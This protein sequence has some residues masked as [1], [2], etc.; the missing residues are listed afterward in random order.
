MA[1]DAGQ[2][3]GQEKPWI[4]VAV[5]TRNR[6]RLLERAVASVLAQLQGQT[7][8]LIVDN[9]SVDDTA[10]VARGL[11]DTSPA[12]RLA[13]EP[14]LGLANA[15]N[16]ALGAAR[17]QWIVFLDDDAVAEPGWLAAYMTFVQA[18]PSPAV[19]AV[20]G[21]VSPEYEVPP[22]AWYSPTANRL[23]LGPE[24]VRV[25]A[26]YGPWGGNI[27]YRR[28]AVLAVGL[29]DPALGRKDQLMAAHEETELNLRLERAGYQIW[30]LPQARIRHR[31]AADRLRLGWCV[32]AAFQSG[33]SKALVRWRGR[34]P[35][36]GRSLWRAGRVLG[37]PLHAGLNLLVAALIWPW[38]HGCRSAAA[39][40]RAA[41]I[42][43]FGWQLTGPMTRPGPESERLDAEAQEAGTKAASSS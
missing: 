36:V 35:G 38:R 26:R 21:P 27:G 40:I 41:E 42:A 12:V 22:P 25:A 34:S 7:E 13:R 11:A 4:T 30:W 23:D 16:T 33:R 6:A 29:F 32:W 8:V 14:R 9:G 43:G 19:A 5:C 20:G 17:G 24:P 18:P 28:E 2:S 31:V 37:T 3:V 39:C 1:V 15:R 10:A